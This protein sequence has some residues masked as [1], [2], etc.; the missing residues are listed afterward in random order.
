MVSFILQR[1]TYLCGFLTHTPK[2]APH[3]DLKRTTFWCHHGNSC[4]TFFFFIALGPC[5]QFQLHYH[6]HLTGIT[7]LIHVTR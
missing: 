7:L 6:H 1:T 5:D 3:V 4:R 2:P